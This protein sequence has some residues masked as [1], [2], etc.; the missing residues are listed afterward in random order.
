MATYNNPRNAYGE[1]LVELGKVDERVVALDADLCKSTMAVLFQNAFPDR[2]FEMGIAEAN[3]MST[4]AG[5]AV[6]GKIPFASSFAVFATGRAYDQIRQTISIGR[7]NVKICGSSCGLSDYGDGSTH[8]S[9]DDVAIMC[10]I[11]NMTVLTPADS[12]E[13][14]LAVKAAAQIQGPVYIRVNRNPIL[15]VLDKDASFE[16]GAFRVLREGKD[17]LLLA[18]GVMVEKALAAA[19]LLEKEGISAKVASVATMK[20]FNYEGAA[21]LAKGMKG[22]V[23]AEEHSY[24]GGLAAATAFAL[25]QSK[26]P[27]DYVAVMDTFGESA[28]NAADLQNA[29]GLTAENIVE[30]AKKLAASKKRAPKKTFK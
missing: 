22:V 24:I 25:R 5:L 3:M 1:A 8:Q 12:T 13:T 14:R 15:D 28:H 10:A 6:S 23:T 26:V 11:P 29:Y 20:P 21:K 4:A 9:I 19:D 16:L 2:Y 30:K 17:I 18:H 7:L 27:M